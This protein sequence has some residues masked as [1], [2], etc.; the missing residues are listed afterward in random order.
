MPTAELRIDGT[1]GYGKEVQ[2][3]NKFVQEGT[4]R[5]NLFR[6]ST[7]GFRGIRMYDTTNVEQH[8]EQYS[9]GDSDLINVEGG[10]IELKDSSKLDLATNDAF[11]DLDTF[12]WRAFKPMKYGRKGSY[13]GN[14]G[15]VTL[16][17]T[18]PKSYIVRYD[19]LG[20]YIA[21]LAEGYA[22]DEPKFASLATLNICFNQTQVAKTLD[23]FYSEAYGGTPGEG[24]YTEQTAR[25]GDKLQDL[26]N[27]LGDGK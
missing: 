4:L 22:M 1:A 17:G 5:M 16:V 13:R 8:G 15:T 27:A 18:L 21:L 23:Y 11:G 6:E 2:V 20:E 19:Y 14:F 12:K 9:T 24:T 25:L 26:K 7:L 10:T 3:R